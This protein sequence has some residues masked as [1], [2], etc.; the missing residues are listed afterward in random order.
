MK[1]HNETFQKNSLL[2]LDEADIKAQRDFKRMSFIFAS[3][4]GRKLEDLD[5]EFGRYLLSVTRP[6]A[7]IDDEEDTVYDMIYFTSPKNLILYLCFLNPRST[8]LEPEGFDHRIQRAC[9]LYPDVKRAF[10]EMREEHLYI[11]YYKHY[12]V[13]K[14]EFEIYKKTGEASEEKK[15]IFDTMIA[16][17]DPLNLEDPKNPYQ[18]LKRELKLKLY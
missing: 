2:S 1:I 13:S 9:Y 3:S 14:E 4:I 6:L 18:F 11:N 5:T 15:R 16:D 17:A 10:Y 8:T 12:G 7:L